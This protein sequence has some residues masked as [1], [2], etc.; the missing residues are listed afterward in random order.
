VTVAAAVSSPSDYQIGAVVSGHLLGLRRLVQMYLL[1]FI[2]N[3]RAESGLLSLPFL[4]QRVSLVD[5]G[6]DFAQ[7]MA[8]A[9]E[10]GQ[11]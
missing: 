5:S 6:A 7:R 8:V 1:Q 3:L 2:P 10:K 11:S 9:R 4:F